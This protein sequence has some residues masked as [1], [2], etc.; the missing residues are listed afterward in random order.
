MTPAAV[1]P[2]RVRLVLRLLDHQ[3]VGDKGM[4]LGNVD[5]LEVREIDG[6]LIITGV[7]SG[8]PG[9]GPRQP[10]LLGDW[11]VAV[12]RRLRPEQQ[13]RPLVVPMSHVR[14]IGSSIEVSSRASEI[15]SG[16]NALEMWL[17]RYVIAR[18]PGATGGE[19]R[20]EGEPTGPSRTAHEELLLHE[21][22]H[23]LSHLI[24]ARVVTREGTPLGE[25]LEA[26]AE[27]FEATGLEV[28]RLRVV[29]IVVGR[30]RLGAELGYTSDPHYGP[31]PLGRLVRLWH[32][33][34]RTIAWDEVERVDWE[35]ATVTV[36]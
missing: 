32:R 14:A 5:N 30:H 24:G 21:D 33:D 17:R 31:W 4:L 19:D 28:G 22:A 29:E 9:H 8:P 16:T 2:D 15:L 7:I 6:R 27:P 35:S 3:I 26:V 25:V 18:I 34:D 23:L 13:P 20:L 1:H 10:G 12:W 11:I 36:R